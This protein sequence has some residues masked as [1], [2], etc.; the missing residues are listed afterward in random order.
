MNFIDC[1]NKK[2]AFENNKKIKAKGK[3]SHYYAAIRL[4]HLS[5]LVSFAVFRVVIYDILF[6]LKGNGPE[7]ADAFHSWGNFIIDFLETK[8]P[9]R[10]TLKGTSFFV[11]RREVFLVVLVI[12]GH[13]D[14]RPAN[15]ANG[16]VFME[17]R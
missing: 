1:N 13:V 8:H 17:K 14:G 16:H 5:R 15:D 10:L 2:I 11:Q 9:L 4:F 6:L 12:K 3:Y 7:T